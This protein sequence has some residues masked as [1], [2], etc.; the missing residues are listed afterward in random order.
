MPTIPPPAIKTDPTT[1]LPFPIS[2]LL[3]PQC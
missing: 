1:S 3:W 2:N